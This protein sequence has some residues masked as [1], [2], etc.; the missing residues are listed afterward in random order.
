VTV[1]NGRFAKGKSGNP[2]G[3]P[4][5][6]KNAISEDFLADVSA[7]WKEHGVEALRQM[8]KEKPAEFVKTVAHLIPRDFHF[9][10]S[11]AEMPKISIAWD[12][13]S[14]LGKMLIEGGAELEVPTPD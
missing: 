4:K 9:Q 3:R 8:I 11:A 12:P 13:T 14:K 2:A 7:A 5:G 10:Q 1:T 6:S